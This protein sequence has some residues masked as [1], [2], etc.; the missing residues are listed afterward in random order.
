MV[1]TRASPTDSFTTAGSMVP[2]ITAMPTKGYPALSPD[3]LSIYFEASDLFE[4]SRPSIGA[5][6]GTPAQIPGINSTSAEQD[7]SITADGLELY[8]ASSRANG[9]ERHLYVAKRTCL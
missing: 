4:A 6:F 1:T 9:T 2:G 7:V 5:P 8:F 3:Q